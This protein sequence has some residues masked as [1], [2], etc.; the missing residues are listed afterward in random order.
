[1][2]AEKQ[3]HCAKSNVQTASWK[4]YKFAFVLY[5]V[6]FFVCTLSKGVQSMIL[7]VHMVNFPFWLTDT[8]YH[9]L[10]DARNI[11]G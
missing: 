8:A 5:A 11:E 9:G 2:A 3:K 7:Y 6:V 4:S 10:P 1:M